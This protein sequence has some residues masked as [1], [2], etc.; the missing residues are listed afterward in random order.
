[1]MIIKNIR[2]VDPGN[3][4]DMIADIEVKDGKIFRVVSHEGEVVSEVSTGGKASTDS[5]SESGNGAAGECDIV[6]DG[7]GLTAAPGLVDVHVHFRDPG[8]EYKE[9]I[10]TGA[11]AAAKGGFTTVVCMANTVPPVD[12][13]ET[14]EAILEK[15]KKAGIHVLQAAAV[16][17]GLGGKELTD[18]EALKAHGAAG[19][20]DDGKPL[21]ESDL[22]KAAMEEAARLNMPLSFHEEDPKF[23]ENNGINH[24]AVSEQL[25]IFGSP[26]LAE[27]SLVARDCMIALHTDRKSVV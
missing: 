7:A 15:G 2:V 14:L 4:C 26:A 10:Q 13:I 22:V 3:K 18:M 19:F 23:I 17:K 20:T 16:T 9:D 6:I 27:D 8:Q 24:G 12:N 1:M 11:A 21:M 25:G 5:K